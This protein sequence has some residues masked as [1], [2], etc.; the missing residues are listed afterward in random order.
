[1]PAP[2]WQTS[3]PGRV[4]TARPDGRARGHR[5]CKRLLPPGRRERQGY[6][7]AARQ[8]GSRAR[9]QTRRR[10]RAAA[11]TG[12]DPDSRP[13]DGRGFKPDAQAQ[14]GHHEARSGQAHRWTGHPARIRRYARHGGRG[15]CQPR[16]G[17]PDHRHRPLAPPRLGVRP[18]ATRIEGLFAER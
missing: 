1:M 16:R 18:H 14:S 6:L 15:H 8:R 3:P 17:C 4:A 5:P 10:S 2:R 9:S 7:V 13:Q 12:P 11:Q